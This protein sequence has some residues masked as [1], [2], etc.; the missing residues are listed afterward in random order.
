MGGRACDGG[1][2]PCYG[3]GMILETAACRHARGAALAERRC[4]WFS[5][6]RTR[7]CQSLFGC[8]LPQPPPP[9]ACVNVSEWAAQAT[10]AALARA[11]ASLF[12]GDHHLMHIGGL[13]G[14][15]LFDGVT[16][17][18]LNVVGIAGEFLD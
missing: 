18:E 14:N 3:I 16:G 2:L 5:Q 10:I 7:D 4:G 11:T 17:P 15:E 6:D 1:S 12:D 8:Y 13:A 9:P